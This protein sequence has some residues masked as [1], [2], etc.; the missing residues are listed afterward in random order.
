MF[1]KLVGDAGNKGILVE[2]GKPFTIKFECLDQDGVVCK[3]G[4]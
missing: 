2:Q 4:E 1:F 3:K